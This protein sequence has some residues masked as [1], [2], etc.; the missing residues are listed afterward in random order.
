[1]SFVDILGRRCNRLPTAIGFQRL[2][3]RNLL[4]AIPCK[5]IRSHVPMTAKALLLNMGRACNLKKVCVL[6]LWDKF[7]RAHAQ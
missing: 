1:M 4:M 2:C 6:S 7:C 5:T 3:L